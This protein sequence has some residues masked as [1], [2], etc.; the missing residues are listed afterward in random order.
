[1]RAVVAHDVSCLMEYKGLSLKEACAKVVKD[2][3]VKM[4]GEGGLIAVDGQG[5]FD[6][7]FNSAGMYRGMRNSAGLEEV[8][9]Y[10]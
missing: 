10:G 9:F 5:N 2:K 3:L 6:F 8:A 4:G 7:C 1:M